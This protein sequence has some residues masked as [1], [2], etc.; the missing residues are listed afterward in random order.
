MAI[1]DIEWRVGEI[2]VKGPS[3]SK[4]IYAFGFNPLNFTDLSNRIP[5]CSALSQAEREY[6]MNTYLAVQA[7]HKSHATVALKLDSYMNTLGEIPNPNFTT[8]KDIPVPLKTKMFNTENVAYQLTDRDGE[9]LTQLVEEKEVSGVIAEL[10][11]VRD[12]HINLARPLETYM[13]EFKFQF[14]DGNR[15]TTASQILKEHRNS[16]LT[17][18]K[19]IRSS[20]AIKIG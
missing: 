9:G 4:D 14:T 15:D 6:Y 12:Q 5:P 10:T 3:G 18:A 19:S 11:I 2:Q 16:V 7:K 1:Y 17:H 8:F 13:E 20:H